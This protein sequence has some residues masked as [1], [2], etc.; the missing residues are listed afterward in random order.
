M[1][2]SYNVCVESILNKKNNVFAPLITGQLHQASPFLTSSNVLF[3]ILLLFVIDLP[4]VSLIQLIDFPLHKLDDF[5][6]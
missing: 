4:L 5:I 6:L 2:W 3:L 1:L